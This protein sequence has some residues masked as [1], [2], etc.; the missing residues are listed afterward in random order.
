VGLPAPACT[1]G[2]DVPGI[3]TPEAAGT[4][5]LGV[6]TL[7]VV[8]PGVVI[9]GTVGPI[10]RLG[11]C[12]VPVGSDTGGSGGPPEPTT[13][14]L[15]VTPP[16]ALVPVDVTC[17]SGWRIGAGTAPGRVL[18]TPPMTPLS[19]LELTGIPGV[20]G[21]DGS[22]TPTDRAVEVLDLDPDRVAERDLNDE[23]RLDPAPPAAPG[24]APVRR[25]RR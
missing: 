13:G 3:V 5:T 23:P 1:P 12:T 4:D 2:S 14:S 16:T 8:T 19:P 18:R 24:A 9:L 17:P 10:E 6:L 15:E 25:T 21:P 7:G 11:S 20:L 22:E